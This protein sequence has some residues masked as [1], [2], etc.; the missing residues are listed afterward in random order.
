MEVLFDFHC[1]V[2]RLTAFF[3]LLMYTCNHCFYSCAQIRGIESKCICAFDKD[4]TK[5]LVVCADGTFLTYN[6]EDKQG[7]C[8]RLSSKRFVKDPGELPDSVIANNNAPMPASQEVGS[9]ATTTTS[10]KPGSGISSEPLT[11]SPD[12][13]SSH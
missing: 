8:Q 11:P 1:L 5:I 3:V 4:S 7:E 10:A 9:P 2:F 12:R 13:S 6:F